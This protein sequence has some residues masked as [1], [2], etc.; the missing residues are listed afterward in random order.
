MPVSWRAPIVSKRPDRVAISPRVIGSPAVLP[1]ATS[2]ALRRAVSGISTDVSELFV[3]LALGAGS[4]APATGMP[5]KAASSVRTHRLLLLLRVNL[6]N[7]I[8]TAHSLS[9]PGR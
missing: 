8:V 9:W 6:P 7:S 1:S 4:A 5:A 3:S 2:T